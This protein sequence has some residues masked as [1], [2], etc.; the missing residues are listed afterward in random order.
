MSSKCCGGDF[1]IVSNLLNLMRHVDDHGVDCVVKKDDGSFIE[2]QIKARSSEVDANQA[3]LFAAIRHE[4]TENF[5]FVFFSEHL[6]KMWIMSSDEF[7]DNIEPNKKGKNE[8][9]RTICFNGNRTDKSTGHKVPYCK[10]KFEQY[11]ATDF[12][13][14]H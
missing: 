11:R 3:A 4:R 1:L 9:T 12:A 2:I 5:Y 8:G 14:F 13:R 6:D 10:K 7:I